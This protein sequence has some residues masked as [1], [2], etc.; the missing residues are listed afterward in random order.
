MLPLDNK[1]GISAIQDSVF[2]QNGLNSIKSMGRDKNPESLREVAKQFEA[3][4]MQ[5]MLK[6]M[7]E[8]NEVFAEG[9]YFDSSQVKFHRDMMDQQMVLNLSTGRG[10]GLAE[11]FYQSMMQ[12]YGQF[13]DKPSTTMNT[14]GALELSDAQE[15]PLKVPELLRYSNIGQSLEMNDPA[16]RVMDQLMKAY[17][18]NGQVDASKEN[19]S[20]KAQGSGEKLPISQ[21]QLAFVSMLKPHAEKAARLLNINPDVLIAQAALETGW[22]KHVI[23]SPQGENS[24]NLFNIKAGEPWQGKSIN[25]ATKEVKG[26]VAYSERADFR[27]YQSYAESFADYVRL[28]KNNNRYQQALSVGNNSGAYADALQDAGYATDPDYAGKIKQLLKSEAIS[29]MSALGKSARSLLSM[30]NHTR[31]QLME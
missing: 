11:H 22:G 10:I 18:G 27:Q 14:D 17:Y 24:F 16:S 5:Q 20:V 13:M 2:D 8:T 3:L 19:A 15:K 30:A 12:S 31:Q 6:T 23:H 4:F 1:P 29:A 26:N 9:N 7:R 25:V 21:S 28:I